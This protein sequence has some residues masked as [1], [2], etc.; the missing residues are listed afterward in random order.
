MSIAFCFGGGGG[1][2]GYQ[3]GVSYSLNKNGIKPDVV[4]GISVGALNGILVAI[5]LHETMKEIWHTI[6]DDKVRKSRSMQYKIRYALHFVGV[7]K[8]YIG[9]W[10]SEPLQSLVRKTILGHTTKCE[11]F[12]GAVEV[13]TN[14]FVHFHIS[15]GTTFTS[16]N[17]DRY[18]KMIVASTAIPIIFEPIEIDG[19]WY[20]D[21]GVHYQMPLKPLSNLIDYKIDYIIG[22]SHKQSR[23]EGGKINN[24]LDMLKWTLPVLLDQTSENDFDRF[25]LINT[26]CKMNGGQ[27]QWRGKQRK[28]YESK[29]FR[30]MRSLSPSTRFHHK[31]GRADFLHG[32]KMAENFTI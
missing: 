25:E 30:P 6:T 8:P 7:T 19:K 24:D 9:Y 17:V 12:C 29:I 22:V 13:G 3:G 11:Y 5:G 14:E 32:Q 1:A 27:F 31:F 16:E 23:F 15:K 4:S 28:Y 2:G 21:G 26:I 10:S 18:V 20:V